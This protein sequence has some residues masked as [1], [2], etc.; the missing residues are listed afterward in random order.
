[1]DLQQ[2]TFSEAQPYFQL[3][4]SERNH[5]SA[6]HIL[7]PIAQHLGENIHFP[8]YIELPINQRNHIF[9]A[10][11]RHLKLHAEKTEMSREDLHLSGPGP[12]AS[13]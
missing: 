5:R 11:A 6:V 1:M 2:A 9:D 7:H 3:P 10:K 4:I 12:P 13:I 8:A